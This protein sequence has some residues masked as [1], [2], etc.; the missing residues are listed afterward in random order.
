MSAS[1]DSD[2]KTNNCDI[3]KL[4]EDGLSSGPKTS[5][6]LLTSILKKVNVN[7]RT[8]YRHL[9]KLKKCKVGDSNVSN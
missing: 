7:K 8:Y 1:D 3:D 6:E 9:E 2:F 5:D 4:I